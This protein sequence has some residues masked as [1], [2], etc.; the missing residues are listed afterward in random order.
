MRPQGKEGHFGVE[1]T[2]RGKFDSSL[3]PSQILQY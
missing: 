3:G 1:S 2:E